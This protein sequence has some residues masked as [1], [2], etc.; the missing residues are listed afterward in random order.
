[1]LTPHAVLINAMQ[2]V[3]LADPFVLAYLCIHKSDLRRSGS[4]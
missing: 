3:E 4:L 1:M 2:L